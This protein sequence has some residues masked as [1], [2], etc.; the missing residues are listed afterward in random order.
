MA[1]APSDLT[2]S[3]LNGAT[4]DQL[5]FWIQKANEDAGKKVLNKTGKVEDLKS[6]LADYYRLDRSAPQAS[7]APVV[8]PLS[9]DQDIQKRQ[10]AHLRDLG[11]E[12]QQTSR[13]GRAFKLCAPSEGEYL[14]ESQLPLE[15]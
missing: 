8:G 5:R 2:C 15:V 7:S 1:T 13:A 9:V 4:G 12:W 6:R 3:A 14:S 11:M 10:W